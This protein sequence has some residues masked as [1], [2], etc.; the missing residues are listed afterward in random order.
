MNLLA[1]AAGLVVV[2]VGL[3]AIVSLQR[4]GFPWLITQKDELPTF[5]ADALQRFMDYS[6]DPHLGWVRR[7]NSSGIENGQS[8]PISFHIDERG[9]RADSLA[10]EPPVIAAFGDSYA[11]CRQVEDDETW[12]A[13]LSSRENFGV[14][15]F[16][17]GNYGVDQALLRYECTALP[18]T[19]RVVVMGF[20]PE[21]ICRIQSYWKHYLEFGNTFAFKPRFIL[22]PE[23]RLV[24][25]ENLVRNSGDFIN[26]RGILPEIREADGFYKRKFR[27]HQFRFPYTASLLRNPLKHSKLM[28]AVAVR[29]M[30]RALGIT[31]SRIE[32]LPFTLVMK[33]NLRDAY[34]LYDDSK[35][36]KL[37]SAIL[38]RFKEE[39]QRR[40]HIPLV[41]VMPQLLDLRLSKNGAA[42]YQGYFAEVAHQLSVLDLTDSFINE[43]F[44][45]LY[46]NDQYGGHL[47][48]EGNRLVADKISTWLMHNHE[49]AR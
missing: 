47:S 13:Q 8:G 25:L 34:R 21:T 40:G 15:N 48:A 11:F 36:T 24:L 33:N 7:A 12:E 18:D 31:N 28:L 14:L 42:P 17:V 10:K 5:D 43:E 32:N 39:A 3:L 49:S 19:V 46:I 6:F 44:E 41:V 37:L 45:K 26:I 20:V 1:L 22:D 35:S 27:S 9:S 4:R 16:G 38:L 2:E 23:G 29:G 30:G